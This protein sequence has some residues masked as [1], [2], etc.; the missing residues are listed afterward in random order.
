MTTDDAVARH[1][2]LHEV[3]HAFTIVVIIDLIR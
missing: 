1:E 2:V 3:Q